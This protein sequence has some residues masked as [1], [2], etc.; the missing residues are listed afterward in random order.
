MSI[1]QTIASFYPP[2][3]ERT[4]HPPLYQLLTF[5]ISLIPFF[6]HSRRLVALLVFPVLLTLCLRAP[7]YTFGDPS[8]D[9]YNTS[10]FVATPIWLVE[11]AILR[12]EDGVG[13]PVWVGRGGGFK[14]K[15]KEGKGAK[16]MASL[17]ERLLWA[18]SLMIP[19]HRGV[20]WDWQVRYIPENS[21]ADLPKWRYVRRQLRKTISA[22][23]YSTIMLVILGFASALEEVLAEHVVQRFVANAIIGW[24]GA[25]WVLNR[26]LCFYNFSAAVSV[27]LGVYEQWQW[28]PLVG[29]LGDAWSVSQMWSVVYHQTMRVVSV[30][31]LPVSPY[32]TV[33]LRG[34]S[35]KLKL[36]K[37]EER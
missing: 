8:V 26:M 18:I 35:E 5:T 3:S 25:F 36:R 28:P 32:G 33:R 13:A 24:A 4:P 22:Y 10:M 30:I 21:D 29:S 14:E 11:F 7:C 19:S 31:L 37:G 17:W 1:I 27:A 16:D 9:Y 20:G 12:P 15:G 2:L 34:K 6:F 23:M